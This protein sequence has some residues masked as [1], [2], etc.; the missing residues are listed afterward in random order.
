[1][2]TNIN[3]LILLLIIFWI[4][5]FLQNSSTLLSSPQPPYH[6]NIEQLTINNRNYRQVLFTTNQKNFQLVLMSLLPGEE[7]GM[8][9]HPRTTQFIRVEKGHGLAIINGKE[10]PMKDGDVVVVPPNSDHNLINIS[11][12]SRLQLYAIYT[13]AEHQPQTVQLVKPKNHH[14]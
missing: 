5:Y 7:I 12:T 4:I 3:P 8:E 14:H 1:M 2:F 11:N 10:Y 13:P 9:N 6:D